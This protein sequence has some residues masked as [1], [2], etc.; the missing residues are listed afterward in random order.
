MVLK[1]IFKPGEVLKVVEKALP[2]MSLFSQPQL[3]LPPTSSS[4]CAGRSSQR[5]C[6]RARTGTPPLCPCS[7]H[8]FLFEG[9]LSQYL[10]LSETF[11]CHQQG[12]DQL[13]SRASVKAIST[14][15][16]KPETTPQN[17]VLP[18]YRKYT[19]GL[20]PRLLL[21]LL[22]QFLSSQPSLF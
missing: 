7:F 3:M 21:W 5:F 17:W 16:W 18:D 1:I 6:G 9:G 20:I 2:I 10:R 19:V 22:T 15:L 4:G 14:L 8:L 11:G 13:I 12:G